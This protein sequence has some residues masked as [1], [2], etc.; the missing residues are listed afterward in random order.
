VRAAAKLV[1]LGPRGWLDLLR[2]QGAIVRWTV[3]MR[4]RHSGHLLDFPR[5]GHGRDPDAGGGE[6]PALEEDCAPEALVRARE[7]AVALDRA[8]R[9][10]I[11]RPL[12]LVRSLAL[13][14]LFEREGIRGSRV[15]LGVR[16][17]RG[18]LESHAWLELRGRIVG[19]DPA[20]VAAFSPVPRLAGQG[21]VGRRSSG[22]ARERASP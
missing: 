9:F 10:G 6:G 15:R 3:A 2:A 21:K 20:R 22:P 17:R 11:L 18:T 13:Q 7:L 4:F 19:D 14:D 1:R 12:C 5:T 16:T 8:A